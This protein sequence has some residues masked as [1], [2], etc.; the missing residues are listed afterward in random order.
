MVSRYLLAGQATQLEG[1]PAH[2]LHCELQARQADPTCAKPGRQA[3]HW[4]EFE[5]SQVRQPTA[6]TTAF[7]QVLSASFFCRFAPTQSP[8]MPR[9]TNRYLEMPHDVQ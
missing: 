7:E 4:L 6:Q 9:L 3:P 8:Q 5:A 1:V 2:W